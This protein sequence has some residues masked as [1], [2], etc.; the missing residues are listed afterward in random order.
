MLSPAKAGRP[1]PVI[2]EPGIVSVVIEESFLRAGC[3]R[4]EPHPA[5]RIFFRTYVRFLLS[6]ALSQGET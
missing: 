5:C 4:R 6:A 1:E 2:P 3:L